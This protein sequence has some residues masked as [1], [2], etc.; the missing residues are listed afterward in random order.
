MGYERTAKHYRVLNLSTG[1][2]GPF[3]SVKFSENKR[4]G[5]YLKQLQRKSIAPPDPKLPEEE[6]DS[7]VL[8][9]LDIF[10]NRD[11]L[12]SM[13]KLWL[14][15]AEDSRNLRPSTPER[16]NKRSSKH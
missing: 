7:I 11:S 4:G 2:V 13:Q 3:S 8:P 10:E 12:S 15:P 9:V 16:E 5:L 6:L 1:K 14:S